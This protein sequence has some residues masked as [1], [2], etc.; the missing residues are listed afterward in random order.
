[1]MPFAVQ[2]GV[3]KGWR[4]KAQKLKGSLLKAAWPLVSARTPAPAEAEYASEEAHSEW[5]ICEVSV[6][7]TNEREQCCT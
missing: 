1:M 7:A 3:V 6:A 5:V 4:L 2:T